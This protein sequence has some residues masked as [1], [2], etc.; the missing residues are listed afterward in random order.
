MRKLA[1]ILSTIVFIALYSCSSQEVED[2]SPSELISEEGILAHLNQLAS[3]EFM[4]RMPF[5]EGEIKTLDYLKNEFANLGLKPGN[6]DSYFQNVPMVELT[7]EL[8]GPMII[9]GENGTLDLEPLSQYVALSRRVKESTKIINA[10]LVFAGYGIDAPEYNWNDYEGLDVEGKIVIV[11]VNDPGFGSD[12]ETFFKGNTMTYYGRWTY[13]YEEAARKG[14]LGVIV[15]H[16]TIPA[17]YPWGV[18]EN[19]W[20]GPQLHLENEQKNMDRCAMEG[21]INFES[22]IKLFE[23]AGIEMSVMDDAKKPG[24]KAVPLN[25]TASLAFSTEIDR[26]ESQNV[27]AT[28]PGS[29]LSDEHL[30]LT[31]HWDHLG[32]GKAIDGDSI[33]NGAVDNGSGT[34]C[35]LEIAKAFAMGKV[36]TRRS[37]TFLAVTAEEQGLLGSAWYSA[38][39]I[40]APQK[41]IANINM[42][43]LN[44]NGKMNDLTVIG[45]GQS[46]LEDIADK[47]VKEQGRYILPDQEPEKGIFF[48]SDHFSFAKIGIPAFYAKGGYDHA[49]KGKEYAEE[50]RMNYLTNQYHKPQDE[51]DTANIDLG[52]MVQDA[53][54]FFKMTKE[55]A[56]SDIYPQWKEGSE[57]KEIREASLKE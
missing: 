31:A 30:I 54:L 42:D 46:E 4:G 47:Y 13:K 12:D 52:G 38:N 24:F 14:A 32:V 50:A 29:D 15:I 57:F 19:G 43:A 34:A 49:E 36:E 22:T 27:I 44:P 10:P 17:G 48:R 39:P 1:Y 9:E 37:V 55:I 35:L 26:S 11:R 7:S 6:G 51:V 41:T 33:Y 16:N 2:Q 25:L 8:E 56:E 45:Y 28:Y 20:S 5:T 40:I 18:V 21:W 53:Q 3:D 23:L